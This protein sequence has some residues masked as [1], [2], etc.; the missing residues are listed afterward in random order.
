MFETAGQLYAVASDRVHQIVHMA[1]LTVS[2]GQPSILAGF[3][4]LHGAPVPVVRLR[5]LFGLEPVEA[6]AY[7]PLILI[8][9]GNMTAALEADL[10]ADVVQLDPAGIQ[11]IG[12]KHSANACAEGLFRWNDRDVILLSTDLLLLAKERECLRELQVA[13]ERRL[14]DLRRDAE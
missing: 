4:N 9:S 8:Q 10:V 13:A 1:G 2:P 14:D 3:L 6:N 11:A 5:R 12:E 7:T